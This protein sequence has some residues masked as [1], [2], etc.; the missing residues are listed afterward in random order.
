MV[1]ENWQ[2]IKCFPNYQV[3]DLGNVANVCLGT[4]EEAYGF[5]WKYE[6]RTD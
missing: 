5:K 3:S 1:V 4:K 2:Q 6:R